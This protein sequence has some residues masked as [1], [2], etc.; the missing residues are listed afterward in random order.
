MKIRAEL[1]LAGCLLLPVAASKA[2]QGK[3]LEKPHRDLENR[4]GGSGWGK[5][6]DRF[7]RGM[8]PCLFGGE[9]RSE[10]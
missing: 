10:D 4:G 8:L 6:F 1:I 3:R 7:D 2:R 5:R 9:V